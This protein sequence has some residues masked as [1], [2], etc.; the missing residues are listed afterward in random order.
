MARGAQQQ[1]QQTFGQANNVFGT[2]N[3]NANNLY[4]SLM[5]ML[6]QEATNPEGFGKAGLA[7]MNTASQQSTGG[8]TAGAVGEGLLAAARNRNSGGAAPALDAAVRSGQQ[9]QSQNAVGIQGENEQLKQAQQQAGLSGMAGLYGKNTG[10]ALSA[11][12]LENQS[13]TALT[14]A[15]QSGWYQNLNQGI[16]SLANVYKALYPQGMSGGGN[17]GG[18]S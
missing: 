18:G 5:P 15:G 4:S 17:S 3:T 14:Q 1:A 7:A 11:L 6:S 12:G 9:Q 10:D 16:G 13:T 8:S 2:S